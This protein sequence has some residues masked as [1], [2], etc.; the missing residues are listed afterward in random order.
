M[1]NGIYR[2][3]VK[4]PEAQ[5]SGAVMLKDGDLAA[6]DPSFGFYGRYSFA[7]G[8]FTADVSCRRLDRHSPPVNLPDLDSF[9]L[10]LEG[11]ARPE[12]ATLTGTIAEAPGLTVP[13]EF[14]WL[15]EA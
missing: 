11:L 3:W 2:V 9:H 8:V 5:T 15:C 12:F 13:F 7:K 6:C 14:A 4:G 10:K 1:R